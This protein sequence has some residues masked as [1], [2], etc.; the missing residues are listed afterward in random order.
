M[1]IRQGFLAREGVVGD[2]NTRI[3]GELDEYAIDYANDH[4]DL[5]I[6]PR[7]V[8]RLRG[9][10]QSR[11]RRRAGEEVKTYKHDFYYRFYVTPLEV[12]FGAVVPPQTRTVT[13]W[14][15]WLDNRVLNEVVF[16]PSDEGLQIDVPALPF[17]FRALREI[18]YN[19][20]VTTEVPSTFSV[21]ITFDFDSGYDPVV[22]VTGSSAV[23]L[24]F[25]PSWKQS[26]FN[27]T[28]MWK[29]TVETGYGGSESR[30]SLRRWPRLRYQYVTR[31]RHENAQALDNLSIGWASRMLA[32]PEW[33]RSMR[34]TSAV[35]A[36]A[37]V[38]PVEDSSYASLVVGAQVVLWSDPLNYEV[39]EILSFT[40]T[41]I[42][43]AKPLIS[44]WPLTAKVMA[45]SICALSS[46]NSTPRVGTTFIDMP[47][48]VDV[49]PRQ[50]GTR[51][52]D[53]P[54]EHTYEGYE[55][56]LRKINWRGPMQ[57]NQVNN[58]SRFDTEPSFFVVNRK[59]PYPALTRSAEFQCRSRDDADALLGFF[60]R[61]RGMQIPVWAP[62]YMDDFTLAAPVAAG[63]N[64]FDFKKNAANV[65]LGADHPLRQH[66]IL[67]MRDGTYFASR[68]V[69]YTDIGGGLVRLQTAAT[70]PFDITPAAVKRFS[71]L[72]FYRLSSDEV[73]FAWLTNTVCEVSVGFTALEVPAPEA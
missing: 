12:A 60:Y 58:E 33:H 64:V 73:T 57:N 65:L 18:E 52:V 1:P 13:V 51:F 14:N 4:Q 16:D 50:S 28:F 7:S 24:P 61:R 45:T 71:F 62:T 31:Q 29:T 38:I 66:V 55:L 48:N 53:L 43:V 37:V 32:V 49:S 10:A 34:L 8:A 72:G 23:L 21:T 69:S 63:V 20:T 68:L 22:L 46:T 17:T 2:R 40:S 42:T 56:Y 3:S 54:E 25:Q 67:Q 35:S 47:V 36:G 6:P 27:E 9:R 39:A 30:S 5:N 44:G 70:A 41:A 19:L 15:A 26:R 59:G 11:A